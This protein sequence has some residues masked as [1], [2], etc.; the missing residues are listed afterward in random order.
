[1]RQRIKNTV[2]IQLDGYSMDGCTN[3][4]LLLKQDSNE[5]QFDCEL[6]TVDKTI[7]HATIPKEEAMKFRAGWAKIQLALTKPDGDPW[8]TDSRDIRIEDLLWRVGYGN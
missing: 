2:S 8:A 7:V 3:I 4:K 6:D 5:F 1:M